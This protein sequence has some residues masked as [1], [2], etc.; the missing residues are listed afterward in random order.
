MKKLKTYLKSDAYKEKVKPELKRMFAVVFF[1]IIYGFGVTWFLEAAFMPMYTGGI[2]GIAQLLRDAIKYH[3]DWNIINNEGLF[4]GAFVIIANIP[5]L[6]LGWFGV[7]K[8][9]T[10]YS[11]VSI[12]IQATILGVIPKIDFGLSA[13]EHS[14]TASVLGGLLVGVGTGGALKYGTSTGGL[15]IVAQ[16]FSFKKGYTVG[17]FSMA[18]NVAIAILG[19]FIVGGQTKDYLGEVYTLAGGA[20]ASY[21]VIRIIISTVMTDRLHTAYQFVSVDIIS[22]NPQE[23]IQTILVKLHRGITLSKVQGAFYHKEKTMMTIIISSYELEAL[24]DMIKKTDDKAFVIV[25]PVK[26][27]FGNFKRKTIA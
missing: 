6:L 21:T 8:K 22:E 15:D 2:P 1:T 25:R 4:L 13:P 27:V 24:R 26:H 18:M 19:G 12:L 5:V 11:L 20:I 14:L 7:S 23:M 10:I 17:F 3:T 9:F 16:Y